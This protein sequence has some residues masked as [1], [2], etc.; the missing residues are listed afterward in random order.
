MFEIKVGTS[1][2]SYDPVMVQPMREEITRVGVKELMTA[3]E[4]DAVVKE[5]GTT[6]IFVNSVCGCAAGMARPALGAIMKHGILPDR[7]VSV[8]AGMEKEAVAKA[9]EYMLP[10]PPSSPSFG[11]IKDGKLVAMLERR[12]IEGH[13]G[14]EVANAI[15]EMITTHA[16]A[17]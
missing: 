14:Q 16:V 3:E 15:L 7:V 4:V 5:T 9:R 12:N 17:K 6:L 13:S 2:P 1:R 11:L 8:F 10:Y